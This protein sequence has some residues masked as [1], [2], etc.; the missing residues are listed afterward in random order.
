MDA[1]MKRLENDI[2]YP[3]LDGQLR[4]MAPLDEL[5]FRLALRSMS[6]F[7]AGDRAWDRRVRQLTKGFSQQDWSAA[8]KR[9]RARRVRLQAIQIGEAQR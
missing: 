1:E 2:R 8:L 9:A 4:E 6:S 3:E 7:V 5:E